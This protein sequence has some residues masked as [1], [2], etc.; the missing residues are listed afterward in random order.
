MQPQVYVIPRPNEAKVLPPTWFIRMC[1]Q[2]VIRPV[3][4]TRDDGMEFDV[5]TS[6]GTVRVDAADILRFDG[7]SVSVEKRA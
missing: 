5:D 7:D 3:V 4:S 2:G 6:Q 1:Q